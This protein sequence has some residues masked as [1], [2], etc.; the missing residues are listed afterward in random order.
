MKKKKKENRGKTKAEREMGDLGEMELRK[1]A[2]ASMAARKRRNLKPNSTSPMM[3][4]KR[5]VIREEGEILP[6]DEDDNKED[7]STDDDDARRFN[8]TRTSFDLGKRV[9]RTGVPSS[10]DIVKPSDK[11]NNSKH[12]ETC[13]RP[14]KTGNHCTTS[15]SNALVPFTAS[16]SSL[17]NGVSGDLVDPAILLNGSSTADDGAAHQLKLASQEKLVIPIATTVT[18]S[19]CPPCVEFEQRVDIESLMK[20]EELHDKEL[21]KA[22]EYRQ[23]CELAERNARK[24]YRE[25]YRA[26]FLANVK[27]TEVYRKREL[28]RPPVLYQ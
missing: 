19:S 3:M 18:N 23:S 8:N 5:K 24:A 27:C 1:K 6:D 26:L 22:Q 10:G 13:P 11:Q 4:K 12:L 9:S 15:G 21:E 14:S 2:V 25:A 16:K 20:L 7:V 17:P 28:F